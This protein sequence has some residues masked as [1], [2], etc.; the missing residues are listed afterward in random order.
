MSPA[1]ALQHAKW[2]VLVYMVA[3]NDLDPTVDGVLDGLRATKNGSDVAI[4]VQVK[5]KGD[6]TTRH[7]IENGKLGPGIPLGK[8]DMGVPATLTSF[9]DWACGEVS[10]DRVCLVISSHG[11]GLD[12]TPALKKRFVHTPYKIAIDGAHF[13]SDADFRVAIEDTDR[14]HVEVLGC[15]ACYM[16][17]IEIGY[18]MRR[19]ASVL[20]A[21]EEE[22]PA[23][24]WPFRE[25]VGEL[26]AKPGMH[27][28]DFAKRAVDHYAD[29]FT[30]TPSPLGR[31]ML[32]A[33][34]LTKLDAFVVALEPLAVALESH[35]ATDG[36]VLATV[37]HATYQCGAGYV[38]FTG[39]V[40]GVIKKLPGLAT[41]GHKA[42]AALSSVCVAHRE[43]GVNG[44][45]GLSIFLPRGNASV[46]T[47]ADWV[48]FARRSSWTAFVAAYIA[49]SAPPP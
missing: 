4:F 38:D 41:L 9:V 3:N 37:R 18:E 2:A 19:V 43:V 22:T 45:T 46:D 44:A 29:D 26:V 16:S 25:I 48:Q 35:V 6:T 13:L 33:S 47:Y 36:A 23:R 8:V 30:K 1:P 21:S 17:M 40:D 20:V 5:R 49:M 12:D 34:D 11:A 7:R 28:L 24:G 14:G 39:F 31:A 32:A 27:P 42:T 10:A 15:D